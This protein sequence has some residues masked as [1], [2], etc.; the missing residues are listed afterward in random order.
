[1]TETAIMRNFN[2]KLPSKIKIG[3]VL[4]SRPYEAAFNNRLGNTQAA[5]AE[6][7]FQD[8]SLLLPAKTASVCSF[9]AAKL[10]EGELRRDAW[11]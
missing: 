3:F 2:R 6:P 4:G 5:G 8:A 10:V 11:I 7:V 9:A 1:V